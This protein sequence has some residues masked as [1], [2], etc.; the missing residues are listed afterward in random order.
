[1]RT[2]LARSNYYDYVPLSDSVNYYA[3]PTCAVLD[4]SDSSDAFHFFFVPRGQ[5]SEILF[6][7]L[8]AFLSF[9]PLF[10]FPSHYLGSLICVLS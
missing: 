6:S 1:M 10:E 5:S 2:L 4:L 7:P 9:Y 8:L 3:S